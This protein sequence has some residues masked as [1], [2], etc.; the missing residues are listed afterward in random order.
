MAFETKVIIKLLAQQV[1]NSKTIREAYGYITKAAE[2]EGM[3]LPSYE[4]W[5]KEVEELQSPEGANK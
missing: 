2:V 1:G 5:Q 4:E 3:T